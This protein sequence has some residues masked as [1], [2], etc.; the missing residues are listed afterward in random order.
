MSLVCPSG[1]VNALGPVAVSGVLAP[2]FAGAPIRIHIVGPPAVGTFDRTTTTDLDGNYRDSFGVTVGSYT[3]QAHFAGDSA[4]G[5]SD[6][7][8]CTVT[9]RPPP[10]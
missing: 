1:G 3:V 2:H 9:V 10:G 8:S 7:P 5:P 6:S 4:N